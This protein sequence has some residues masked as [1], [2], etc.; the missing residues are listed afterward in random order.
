MEKILI[1][2]CPSSGK[3]TLSKVL[4]KR[5]NLPILHLDRV[6]HIDNT[7]QISR[8][9]LKEKIHEFIKEND[10]FIIDGNYSATLAFR[11]QFATTIILLDFPTEICLSN[12]KARTKPGIVRD[13]IAPGF[14][15]SILEPEFVEF[16]NSFNETRLPR[17]YSLIQE[18]NGNVYIIKSYDEMDSF[19]NSIK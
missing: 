10:K 8:E 4:A 9:E 15:N 7:H 12:I 16:V 18:F 6:Y 14:D 3:S 11:M 13:D 2:R 17:I 19:L 1:I 5:L